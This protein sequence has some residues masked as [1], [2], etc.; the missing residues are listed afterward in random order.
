MNHSITN[1]QIAFMIFAVVVG[2][3]IINLP[4]TTAAEVGTGAWIPIAI[5]TIIVAIFTYFISYLGYSHENQTLFEYGQ[6][7]V[8]KKL[9]KLII[10]I[11]IIYFIFLLSYLVRSYS[12]IV[13]SIFLQKTPVWA[14][15]IFLLLVVS[16]GLTKDLKTI[17]RVT[18]I[19]IFLVIIG[20][21]FIQIIVATQGKIVNIRPILGVEDIMTYAK[22][23]FELFLPFIGLEIIMFIPLNKKINKSI[24]K[25]SILSIVFIGL[26]YIFV[27]EST[28]SVVGVE[29]I[30]RYDVSV[31]KVLKGIDLPYLEVLKRLDGFYVIFWTMNLFCDVYI[32]SYL[33][34]KQSEKFFK[35]ISPNIIIFIVIAIVFILSQIPKTPS[36]IR[37]LPTIAKNLGIITL[38]IIPL[39]LFIAMKVK[40]NDK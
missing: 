24:I 32:V 22:A 23:S 36:E 18:E 2:Y 31:F 11:Y 8:G 10:I 15:S 13:T 27:I 1:R 38:M 34:L 28:I 6:K 16:Y 7:L 5:N 33:I 37:M 39:I 25:Y 29:D 17:A 9:G 14:I 20:F 35:K 12:E 4:N 40:K 19:Y 3:G 30:I 26:L 21:V